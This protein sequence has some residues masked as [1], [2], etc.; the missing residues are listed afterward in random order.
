[1]G[2]RL[3]PTPQPWWRV[4]APHMLL[5]GAFLPSPSSSSKIAEVSA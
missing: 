4:P 1:M 2:S 3:L 5:A